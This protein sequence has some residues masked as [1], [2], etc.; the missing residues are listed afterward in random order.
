M[1]LLYDVSRTVGIQ[2]EVGA[3]VLDRYLPRYDRGEGR[4]EVRKNGC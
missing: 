1:P 4:P 2:V 3:G